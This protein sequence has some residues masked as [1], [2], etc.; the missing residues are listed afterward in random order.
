MAGDNSTRSGHI[1]DEVQG[2]KV[3]KAHLLTQETTLRALTVSVNHKFQAF[4]G[5]FDEIAN[6]LDALAIGANRNRNDDRRR[7]RDDFAQGQPINRPVLHI[8]IDNLS[9]MMIQMKRKTSCL[10]IINPQEVVVD[11]RVTTKRI[12]VISDL[13]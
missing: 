5:C 7:P 11:I 6:R 1:H 4:K 8:T 9:T 12:M 3:L 13:R 2:I 10:T